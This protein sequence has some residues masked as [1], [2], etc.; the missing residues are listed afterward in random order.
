VTADSFETACGSEPTRRTLTARGRR[1]CV[2]APREGL[3]ASLRL[4]DQVLLQ[5]IDAER[6]ADRVT[7]PVTVGARDLEIEGAVDAHRTHALDPVTQLAAI[8]GRQHCAR[9]SGLHR[10]RV[11]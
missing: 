6:V 2:P 7:C 8:E 10:M 9:R 11:L 4:L 1:T 3:Q 5:R